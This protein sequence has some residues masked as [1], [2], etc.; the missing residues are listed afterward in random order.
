MKEL[1]GLRQ[2]IDAVDAELVGLLRRRMEIAGEIA[3]YKRDQG[4]AVEDA[5][6]E[7]AVLAR[8]SDLADEPYAQY[9]RGV[10]AAIFQ[11]SKSYQRMQM[12]GEF[13]LAGQ[14]EAALKVQAAFPERATVACWGGHT[15]LACKRLF[16]Q[17]EITLS[18]SY[19]AVFQAV[20]EGLCQFGVL[21]EDEGVYELLW[22][23]GLPIVRTAR[24]HMPGG[25][26][27]RYLCI[28]RNL[29]IYPGANRISLLL[30][31]PDAPGSVYGLLTRFA[32]LSLDVIG[33]RSGPKPDGAH[34][35]ML[36]LEL[37]ASASSPEV[38]GLLGALA[39][40][41]EHFTF[42]GAYNEI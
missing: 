8:V 19:Q 38:R 21:P 29:A 40:E 33:L 5:G 1:A 25:A 34:A 12:G 15:K 37:A 31:V 24:L 11:A 28:A 35:F 20:Q 10:Y 6:R 23:H 36:Y 4:L 13:P 7:K 16:P 2:E 22:A 30:G 17:A 42:L 27:A 9:A 26:D 32:A 39:M 41:N 3:A 18:H 14:I